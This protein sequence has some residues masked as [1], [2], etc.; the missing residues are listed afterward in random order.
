MQAKIQKLINKYKTD[1]G[2]AEN[3][4]EPKSRIFESV[5]IFINGYTGM[6]NNPASI[7]EIGID[8]YQFPCCERQLGS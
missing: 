7:R 8:R 2:H 4:D 6:Q 1:S 5:A 3:E